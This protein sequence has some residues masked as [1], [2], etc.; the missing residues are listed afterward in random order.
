MTVWD[1]WRTVIDI[2]WGPHGPL[3]WFKNP[4][5]DALLQQLWGRGGA[6]AALEAFKMPVS[7]V[8]PLS[9]IVRYLTRASLPNLLRWNNPGDVVRLRSLLALRSL[10]VRTAL[11]I[12]GTL[13]GAAVLVTALSTQLDNGNL[14]AN[15]Q[16]EI[17][18]FSRNQETVRSETMARTGLA[19]PD[20][21]AS[22]QSEKADQ[23]VIGHGGGTADLQL[24]R[25]EFYRHPIP[26]Y[27][28]PPPIPVYKELQSMPVYER[29]QPMPVFERAQ[30]MP[31]FERAQPM[32][33]FERAQPMPVYQELRHVEVT[34]PKKSKGQKILEGLAIGAAIAAPL[35]QGIVDAKRAGKA[36][37]A[38]P[39]GLCENPAYAPAYAKWLQ[40][41]Q[42]GQAGKYVTDPNTPDNR[43]VAKFIPCP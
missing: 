8:V 12:T 41:V 17:D 14:P 35:V 29:V 15:I 11:P 33:V 5:D 6:Q 16:S 7:K 42:K 19:T 1:A 36:A 38:S 26:I 23:K 28:P 39:E 34:Q 13:G 27:Q 40:D 43:I 30:P 3:P 4:G 2:V 22:N 37:A 21:G 10:A 24:S 31:V 18:G 32:P 20:S 9:L 25:P